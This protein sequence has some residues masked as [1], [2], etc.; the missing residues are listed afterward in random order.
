MRITVYVQS[1]LKCTSW[2]GTCQA[3]IFVESWQGHVSKRISANETFLTNFGATNMI[4]L[5]QMRYDESNVIME[6]QIFLVVKVTWW[7]LWMMVVRSHSFRQQ[8]NIDVVNLV[9][10]EKKH[11]IFDDYSLPLSIYLWSICRDDMWNMG[12]W[13]NY[14]SCECLSAIDFPLES[15]S[16]ARRC[17]QCKWMLIC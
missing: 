2:K 13:T 4:A 5:P 3:H 17:Q 16:D 8:P 14:S 6:A 7:R 11:V 1:T 9:E 10:H 15:T 12:G